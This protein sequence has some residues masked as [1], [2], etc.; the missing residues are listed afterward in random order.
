MTNQANILDPNL[1]QSFES[2]LMSSANISQVEATT[3]MDEIQNNAMNIINSEDPEIQKR[4][5]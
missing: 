2:F 1:Q 4:H 3:Q 5:T